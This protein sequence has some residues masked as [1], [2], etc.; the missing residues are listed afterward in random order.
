LS[1]A[2]MALGFLGFLR[3]RSRDRGYVGPVLVMALAGFVKHNIIAMPL[4]AF[5]WLGLNRR[6]EFIKC[7]AV[8]A[9]V[10]VTGTAICYAAFGHDL[11]VHMLSPRQYSVR[12]A[13]QSYVNLQWV[14][15]GLRACICNSCARWRDP[16]V[17][18][19]SGFI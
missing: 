4:T 18:L 3:A 13:I 15:V 5:A 8:A 19:C 16:S 7:L 6:H 1:H 9:V 14:A 17:R 10:T 11:F 12:T 2:I